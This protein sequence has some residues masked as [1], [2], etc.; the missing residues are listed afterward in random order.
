MVKHA[1]Q[2]KSGIK[3]CFDVIVNI[4]T[5]HHVYKKDYV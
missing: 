5:K 3:I 4:R 1:I 2:I